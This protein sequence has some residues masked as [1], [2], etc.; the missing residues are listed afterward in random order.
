[1]KYKKAVFSTAYFPP[2]S[3]FTYML[4]AENAII[5]GYEHYHK[6]SYRN[7]CNIY[8]SNGQQ[9]LVIPV[10]KPLGNHTPTNQIQISFR[11]PW[12]RTHWRSIESAYNKS[13]FFMYYGEEIK[14]LLNNEE[15]NLV[16]YNRA[17]CNGLFDILEMEI[18][19][20]STEKYYEGSSADYRNSISPKSSIPEMNSLL[21]KKPY[22]QIFEDRFGFISDLSIL[23][24]LFH[25]GPESGYYL[26]L[27]SKELTTN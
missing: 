22:Y 14:T 27:L 8:N 2:I 3:Y 10:S 21:N 19:I 1:M 25:M 20:E 13:P 5:D 17:I 26:D 6:Q 9:S 11:E 7:R 16:T 4:A 12:Q 15:Q 23:D 18:D 24:L